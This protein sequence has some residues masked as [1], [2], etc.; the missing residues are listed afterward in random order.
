MGEK[1]TEEKQTLEKEVN[2]LRVEVCE[3]NQQVKSFIELD[4]EK[5]QTIQKMN[6][7]FKEFIL[8]QDATHQKEMAEER[9]HKEA[10]ERDNVQIVLT[11][12][13]NY[14]DQNKRIEFLTNQIMILSKPKEDSVSSLN[15]E[16]IVKL[17]LTFFTVGSI[18]WAYKKIYEKVVDIL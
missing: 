11:S 6:N 4:R 15:T 17:A 3:L 2:L 10:L 14:E 12:Q 16:K 5:T 8:N 9:K 18:V 7:E 13:K 1:R